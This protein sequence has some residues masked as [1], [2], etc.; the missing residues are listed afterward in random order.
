MRAEDLRNEAV[1]VPIKTAVEADINWCA[2]SLNIWINMLRNR[3][4]GLRL[5]QP[6][7]DQS[8]W[9]IG[10]WRFIVVEDICISCEAMQTSIYKSD[11][12]ATLSF[13]CDWVG[14]YQNQLSCSIRD[15]DTTPQAS[16]VWTYSLRLIFSIIP[17]NLCQVFITLGDYVYRV[18]MPWTPNHTWFEYQHQSH[19][20]LACWRDYLPPSYT[21]R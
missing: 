13:D 1:Q 8:A 3:L 17:H 6:K 14:R 15:W 9:V 21:Q 5:T 2:L 19:Q 7:H 10:R 16:T 18:L 4:D 20:R 12:Y 11:M